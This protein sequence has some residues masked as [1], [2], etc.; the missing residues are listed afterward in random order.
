METPGKPG[1]RRTVRDTTDATPL[2]NT[3][4]SPAAAAVATAPS[5][6]RAAQPT[7]PRPTA[8]AR[9]KRRFRPLLLIALMTTAAAALLLISRV[10]PDLSARPEYQ[11]TAAQ[12]QLSTPPRWIPADIREQVFGKAAES[13]PLCLLDDALSERLAAAFH[14]HPWVLRVIRVRK[15]WPAQVHVDVE[16][17]RPVA[18]ITAID[19]FYPVDEHGVL[20]PSRD[21][22]P[23]DLRR[24]PIIEN[25]SS[26]P[27]GRVGEAW[28]D[29]VVNEATAL[30][31]AL[32][33]PSPE[34]VSW[35]NQ[36]SLAAIVVPRTSSLK[37]PV[38]DLEFELRTAG[39]SAVMWGRGP[40]SL[41]PA[42]LS[43]SRKLE[44]LAE[45]TQR[46]G[47]LDDAQGPWQ[48]DIRP[49]QGIRRSL[50]A[51]E[52]GRRPQTR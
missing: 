13:G 14:T 1:R 43:T 32:L 49:W 50:L 48:L 52:P 30:A 28:G 22:A 5:T 37:A 18:M 11:I 19:G 25:V 3:A 7:T 24:Y 35:W 15:S 51:A 31:A 36:L 44:R 23:A 10:L 34:D 9:R 4:A 39:G 45:F 40:G 42:E 21:F 17:R 47:P 12:I 26:V 20:L 29:P 41:H 2:T 27:L 46:F 6:P 33:E 38:D 8:T 16:W